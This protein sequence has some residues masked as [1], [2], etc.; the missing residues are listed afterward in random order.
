MRMRILTPTRVIADRKV[1]KICGEAPE[2]AYCLLPRHVDLV[3]VQ[4]PGLLS[5]APRD[6]APQWVAVDEG[7]LVKRGDEV[8]ISVRDATPGT[9]LEALQEVVEEHFAKLNRREREA[10]AAAARLEADF[11]RRFLEMSEDVRT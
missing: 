7:V 2:G 5:Y 9:D 10:R 11:V 3:A 4:V 8:W 6:G 1:K